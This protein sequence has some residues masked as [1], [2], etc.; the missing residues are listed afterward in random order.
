MRTRTIDIF[1]P[2]A[3][4]A[5]ARFFSL[6]KGPDAR[7][8]PPV[9]MDWVDFTGELNDFADTAALIENLDMVISIDTSVAHLAGA[10]GK[11]V[12]VLI[13]FQNDF[14]W[15]LDREDTPWYSRMRLFRQKYREDWVE[16][17]ERMRQELEVMS[18]GRVL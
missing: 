11:T 6:Q 5:G 17:I 12:W 15:L 7:Q 10:L 14:R 8:T 9:G 13:P 1:G 2:L 16:V 4:V 18:A 3:K